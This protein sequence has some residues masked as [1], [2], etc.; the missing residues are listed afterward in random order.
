MIS[1]Y[2]DGGRCRLHTGRTGRLW[3]WGLELRMKRRA[4][5]GSWAANRL[6]A[7][8]HPGEAV[9]MIRSES[10]WL[11]SQKWMASQGGD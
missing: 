2:K 10:Q 7:V 5:P 1:A 9:T 4:G 11:T 6:K 3:S 8:A